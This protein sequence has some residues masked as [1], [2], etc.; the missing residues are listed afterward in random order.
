MRILCLCPTYGRPRLVANALACFLAQDYPTDKR[1]LLILDDL[2]Q[3]PSEDGKDWELIST[4]ERFPS[5]PAKYNAMLVAEGFPDSFPWDAVAV[6]DDDDI[7][8]PWHLPSAAAALGTGSVRSCKPS[9]IWSLHRPFGAEGPGP[10]LEPG[11]GRFHCSLV[12]ASWTLR[13]LGGWIQTRRAD[14]DQQQIK[15]TAPAVDMLPHC[16]ERCP[17]FVYRWASTNAAHCSALMRSP[18]NEDWYDRYW[19]RDATPVGRL[20]PGFDDETLRVYRRITGRSPI[21]PLAMTTPQHPAGDTLS[22]RYKVAPTH[23]L[24]S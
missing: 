4:R 20:L 14:F 10:W 3:L 2:G 12:I 16:P 19:P 22:L 8:L 1:K 21:L 6:W 24:Q 11:A 15:A 23:L 18:D 17:G 7:Y 9:Q 13:E 5:L